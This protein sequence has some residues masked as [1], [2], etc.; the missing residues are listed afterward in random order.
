MREELQ[1]PNYKEFNDYYAA[2]KTS[3]RSKHHE[4]N[5]LRFCDLGEELV[6]RM[7]PFSIGYYQVAIGS[8]LKAT[9][10]VFDLR[11]EIEEYQTKRKQYPTLQDY[12]PELLKIFM[13]SNP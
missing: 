5:V 8:D 7:G 4:F 3:L 11:E 13:N 1:I 12:Y 10:G 6:P 9:V 2:A